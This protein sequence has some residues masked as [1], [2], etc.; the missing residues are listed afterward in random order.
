MNLDQNLDQI[1]GMERWFGLNLDQEFGQKSIHCLVS[2]DG[3]ISVSP[4][5]VSKNPN[6]SETETETAKN[7]IKPNR[8]KPN[9]NRNR[10]FKNRTRNRLCG[11]GYS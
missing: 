5:G 1:V 9:R 11:S 3:F 6:K 8:I 7:R 2:G 4:L 10:K